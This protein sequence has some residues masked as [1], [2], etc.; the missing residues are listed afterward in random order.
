MTF[1]QSH[2]DGQTP[3]R[4]SQ[5]STTAA[6][7]PGVQVLNSPPGRD[8]VSLFDA[9]S[10]EPRRFVL[11]ETS[12]AQPPRIIYWYGPRPLSHQSFATVGKDFIIKDVGVVD[13]RLDNP[14]PPLPAEKVTGATRTRYEDNDTVIFNGQI[15]PQLIKVGSGTL[16]IRGEISPAIPATQPTTQP[17][18]ATAPSGSDWP[19]SRSLKSMAIQLRLENQALHRIYGTE[20]PIVRDSDRRMLHVDELVANLAT[21]SI[22]HQDDE[23]ESRAPISE[24]KAILLQFFHLEHELAALAP[25]D[26]RSQELKIRLDFIRQSYIEKK[27]RLAAT[28]PAAE[29]E[30]IST[31]LSAA[32]AV[33]IDG[34][35]APAVAIDLADANDADNSETILQLLRSRLAQ[36]QLARA[37]LLQTYGPQHPQIAVVDGQLR[38]I[39]SSVA[40]TQL[41]ASG[42]RDNAFESD[43]DV[44]TVK[45]VLR[46]ILSTQYS[47]QETLTLGPEHPSVKSLSTKLDAMRRDYDTLTAKFASQLPKDKFSLLRQRFAHAE[48]VAMGKVPLPRSALAP[49]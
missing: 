34:A 12:A 26:R 27:K 28:L 35:K 37:R 44:R 11:G 10:L 29:Y 4:S 2:A 5:S 13:F 19:S 20:H 41:L 36:V 48:S 46:E 18:P 25:A 16:Q 23:F 38:S 17:I 30:K 14:N 15:A 7:Q 21:I 45:Q 3:T 33:M 6:T 8:N 39:E 31:R 43:T 47:I 1:R 9:F 22:G 24:M 32:E 40:I 49:N 42:E